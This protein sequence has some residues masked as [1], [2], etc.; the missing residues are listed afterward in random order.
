MVSSGTDFI[1]S[2]PKS[3]P[4]Y[5]LMFDDQTELLKDIL[6][7]CPVLDNRTGVLSPKGGDPFNEPGTI[8]LKRDLGRSSRLM[9]EF[10]GDEKKHQYWN[11]KID[12]RFLIPNELTYGVQDIGGS[13]VSFQDYGNV[14]SPGAIIKASVILSVYTLKSR[15][16]GESTAYAKLDPIQ[17]RVLANGEVATHLKPGRA[18]KL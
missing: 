13:D 3:P 15:E 17:M 6:I 8:L 14:V 2:N 5:E 10:Q 4:D 9:F 12:G 11:E 16:N 18:L 1:Q 7:T